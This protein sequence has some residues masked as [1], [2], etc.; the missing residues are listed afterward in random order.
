L[1]V[2][3]G[4]LKAVLVAILAT[5]I[6]VAVVAP[7]TTLAGDPPGLARFMTAIGRIESGGDY[8][9]R[10]A[11]TGAYGKYQILPSS[12]RAWARTYLGDASAPPT[13]ANQDIVAAGKMRSLYR[14]LDSWRR[15]AYWWLTGSDRTSGWSSYA[16]GYVSRVMAYYA[17]ASDAKVAGVPA[18]APAAVRHRF[19]ESNAAVVYSGTWRSASL[20]AYAG[21][22]VRYANGAGASASLTFTG[23]QVAWYGPV[24]PT[25]GQARVYIDGAYAGKVDLHRRSFSAR[26]TLFSR[27]W[28]D[29]AEHTI[30]IEVVGT[31]GH[32]MV[33]VDEF[34]VTD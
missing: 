31:A 23:H 24:G 33:A 2:P 7:A 32:P 14:W 5:I 28:S 10:N 11:R 9:S 16:S 6:L 4:R 12:W 26:K 34:V 25:R 1:R 19:S 27:T 21:G 15:V 17:A 3:H 29:A 30:R 20:R 18:A 13:V 8:T 22:A